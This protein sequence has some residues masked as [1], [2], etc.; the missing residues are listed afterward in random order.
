ERRKRAYGS[1]QV[2]A[3]T[4]GLRNEQSHLLLK[5]EGTEEQY[6]PHVWFDV[7]LWA[8]CV[9]YAAQKLIALDPKHADDYRR[10]ADEYM[11]QLAELHEWCER[12]LSRIP[13]EQRVM[14]TAHDAFGYFGQAYGVEVRGLQGISTADEADQAT[15]DELVDLLVKRKVKAVFAESSVPPKRIRSLIEACAARGHKVVEGGQLFS[16]AMGPEGTAQGEYIGMV[17]HNVE[18]IVGAL[19]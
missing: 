15:A 6:D 4:D 13:K 16:D 3:V 2:Y 14:V 12:E 19:K 7:L 11:G 5:V 10:N 1:E 18:T 17:K 9:D 8:K